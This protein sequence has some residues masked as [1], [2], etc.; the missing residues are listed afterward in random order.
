[1]ELPSYFNDFLSEIRPTQNQRDD[2][3]A[4][5]R[6]LRERL[7]DDKDLAPIIVS[8]FIQGS[9]RRATAIRP[10]EGTRSDVDVIVVTNLNPSTT[11]PDTALKKFVPFLDKHYKDK[12]RIQGRSIGIELSYVDLDL[13]PT[14]APSEVD[15]TA[16]RSA[17]V[18]SEDTPEDVDDWRLVPSWLP[19]S[20][21]GALTSI[22][23]LEQAKKQP[24]WKLEPLLI[25]DRDAKKWDRT[26]PI[27][28]IQATWD[29]NG[30]CNR[31]YLGV[32]KALRWWRRVNHPEPERP[33]GY[34]LEHLIWHC[35]PDKIEYIATGV[36]FTLEE[37]A[38]RYAGYAAV[39]TTPSLPDHGVPE[40]NVLHR[41]TGEDF[42]QFYS[43]ACDGAKTA[44]RALDA[45]TVRESAKAWREL[46]GDK[47][48][49]PPP[50]GNGGE[51]FDKGGYTPRTA[52]T[53]IGGGRFAR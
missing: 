22:K 7:H 5:H 19:L 41:I 43:Q 50:D 27:A 28:Q 11:T 33:K 1:M 48:P 44:R 12:Y 38:R 10:H 9:Y 31:C 14:A 16:L 46:F 49:P 36:T 17:A 47:F 8:T 53:I 34:P 40:H 37:I 20:A 4:G 52:A 39:K 45:D 30:Q 23:L 15:A 29:K 3:R 25:P 2:A 35:C 21:R 24:Q 42:A 32:V 51:G 6:T 26:H 13:V 18:V